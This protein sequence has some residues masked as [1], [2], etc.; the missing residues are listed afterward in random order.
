MRRSYYSLIGLAL[1][2]ACAAGQGHREAPPSAGQADPPGLEAVAIVERKGKPAFCSGTALSERL[3][4]TALHCVQE[5]GAGS[6]DPPAA[7]RVGFGAATTDPDLRWV[8]VSE[9]RRPDPAYLDQ[10]EDLQGK[11][12]AVLIL[13][14][15]FEGRTF[16][17]PQQ[18]PLPAIG[19]KLTVMG[20]G[21]DRYGLVGRRHLTAVTV[22]GHRPD[23]FTFQGGGCLGDS[24]GPIIDAEGRLIGLVSI[25][26]SP[27]CTPN[28]DRIGQPLAPF[29]DFIVDQLLRGGQ[30]N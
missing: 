23:G 13:Q 30:N 5:L 16:A 19:S 28:F 4:L 15:P 20:F 11:D 8:A 27:H 2:A 1:L 3:V 26:T 25:A 29:A 10:I 7:F 22:T 14:A 12:F 18:V 24:G 17:L 6:P 9:V 21:E